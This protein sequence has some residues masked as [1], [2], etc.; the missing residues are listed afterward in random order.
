M[1]LGLARTA[2]APGPEPER[3]WPNSPN[4]PSGLDTPG[5]ELSNFPLPPL[6]TRHPVFRSLSASLKL[7]LWID[8]TSSKAKPCLASPPLLSSIAEVVSSPASSHELLANFERPRPL[9]TCNLPASRQRRSATAPIGDPSP[10]QIPSERVFH[11]VRWKSWICCRSQPKSDGLTALNTPFSIP[12]S[13]DLPVPAA[14]YRVHLS[15]LSPITP[16]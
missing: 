5:S 9:A 1:G 16:S 3:T 12:R 10:R 14:H 13:E 15:P 4:H 6:E 11:V 2:T 7:A 8:C